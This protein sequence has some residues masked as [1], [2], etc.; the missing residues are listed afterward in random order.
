MMV[1]IL[2]YVFLFFGLYSYLIYPLVVFLLAEALGSPWRQGSDKPSISII[3]SVYNEEDVIRAKLENALALNYPADRMQIHVVSDGSTDNTHEI[4]SSFS[5][6]RITLHAYDDRAG[7]T[8]CLN[9]VVPQTEGD[10][11]LFTDANSMFPADLLQAV[12]ANFTDPAIGLVTGWT[13]YRNAAGEEESAGLYARL[14][15]FTKESE[16]RLDSCVGADGA[17]F[18]LRRELYQPLQEG[19]INDFVIPLNVVAQQGRVVL[20]PLVYCYERPS[21]GQGKEFKR[22]IRITNRT[23]WAI[24]RHRHFLDPQKYGW[25]AF[26]LFSHKVLR[27][28]VPFFFLGTLVTALTLAGHSV[29]FGAMVVAQLLFVGFGLAALRWSAG[30]RFGQ[31]SSF[32]L[33]TISAQA[34]G[35]WRFIRGKRDVMWT[36][37]R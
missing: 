32:F 31:L 29:F 21:Q 22:Q 26:F 7:K 11:L 6:P 1:E 12:A 37:Q 20:D 2:F 3:I 5:D 15:R 35:W 27:F 17:V 28:L 8:I 34:L 25:F 16:S 9:R 30:G 36:P 4:V 13:R 18:A 19:D 10:I 24:F 33:L 23:L 14:E